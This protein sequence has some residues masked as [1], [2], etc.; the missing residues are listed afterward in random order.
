MNYII[1][2]LTFINFLYDNLEDNKIERQ[3]L[4][5]EIISINSYNFSNFVKRLN[6]HFEMF[7]RVID[8]II[9]SK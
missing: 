9:D 6:N 1:D 3:T 7:Y 8:G 2:E 4:Y 5:H